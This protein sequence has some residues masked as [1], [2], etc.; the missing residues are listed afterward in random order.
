M[1]LKRGHFKYTC[2]LCNY[3]MEQTT[4]AL[5]EYW[6]TLKFKLGHELDLTEWH[7]CSTCNPHTSHPQHLIF[8]VLAKWFKLRAKAV[9]NG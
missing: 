6:T 1:S 8:K 3:S 9:T 7:I 5:P 2:D 4:A